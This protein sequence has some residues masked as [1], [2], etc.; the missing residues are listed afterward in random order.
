MKTLFLIPARGGSKGI[1]GKNLRRLGG[2]PLICYAIDTA[3][4]LT[5]DE[6]ICVSTDDEKIIKAVR[7]YGL[8]V[9]FKR[10]ARLATDTA[11]MYGT[12]LHAIDFF[13]KQGIKFD[14]LVLLQPTS[15]FR[16]LSLLKK[17]M[18]MFDNSADMVVSVKETRSNPYF[19]LFEE[20][21]DGF[22]VKSKSGN[23]TRRQDCPKVYEYT[24]SFFVMNIAS[25][26]KKP[27]HRFTKIRK[28][29]TGDEFSVDLDTPADWEWAEY[30]LKTKKVNY[31]YK[32]K[33]R[34]NATKTP[35]H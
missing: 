8:R 13:E 1:P 3:R 10:P 12:L 24:G 17:A 9:P 26:K 29:E 35:K 31:A 27:P 20:N 15:P 5:G 23:F 11:P 4:Q 6:N 2:K 33:K 18:K 7:K 30:L 32:T 25:L 14:A 19:V 21:R 34:K 22:L 28:F 16:N